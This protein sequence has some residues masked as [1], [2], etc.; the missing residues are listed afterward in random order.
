MPLYDYQCKNGHVQKDVLEAHNAND[1]E[2]LCPECNESMHRK[3]GRISVRYKN[4]DHYNNMKHS[5]RRALWNS[6][7]P[8]DKRK[9]TF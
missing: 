6:P 4:F 8:A 5:E 7:D 3:P 9:L 1:N 2:H